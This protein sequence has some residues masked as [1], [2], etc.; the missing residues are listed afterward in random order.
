MQLQS[1]VEVMEDQVDLEAQ[2]QVIQDQI[3]VLHQ[4]PQ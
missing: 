4:A 1:V 3:Q 2:L